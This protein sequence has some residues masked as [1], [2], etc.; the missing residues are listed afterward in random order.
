MNILTCNVWRLKLLRASTTR[1]QSLQALELCLKYLSARKIEGAFFEFG[2]LFG[3]IPLHADFLFSRSR[4]FAR[5]DIV[6]FDSFQ[7]LPDKILDSEKATFKK[8]DLAYPIENYKR[9]LSRYKVI[10]K[11]VQVYPGW[12]EE[13]LRNYSDKKQIALAWIDA[14]LFSSTSEVLAFLNN[15]LV[16]QALIV[17]DDYWVAKLNEGGPSLALKRWSKQE[18]VSSDFKLIPWRSFHWAGEIFIYHELN[19]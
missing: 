18:N 9:R 7:G 17:I 6:V 8:G 12:F 4:G 5:R 2:T 1:R 15:K 10:Q 14:D 19:E 13:S 16:D 11:D 3:D